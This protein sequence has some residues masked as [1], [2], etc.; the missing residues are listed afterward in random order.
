MSEATEQSQ[1]ETNEAPYLLQVFRETAKMFGPALFSLGVVTGLATV[2]NNA[3]PSEESV[4]YTADQNILM[5]FQR[6]GD[7]NLTHSSAYGLTRTFDLNN[8]NVCVS[9]AG[10]GQ[11]WLVPHAVDEI[12]CKPI[13]EANL[14]HIQDLLRRADAPQNVRV[15]YTAM[16]AASLNV[17]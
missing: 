6:T 16:Q 12:Q 3:I 5:A 13:T 1:T 14:S 4:T 15:S 9:K 8:G 10:F 2:A 11:N 7:L 17:N